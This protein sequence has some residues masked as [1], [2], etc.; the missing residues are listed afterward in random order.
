MN[1]IE[2]NCISVDSSINSDWQMPIEI[3]FWFQSKDECFPGWF[4]DENSLAEAEMEF[5]F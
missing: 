2:I 5:L 1:L 4:F 3:S